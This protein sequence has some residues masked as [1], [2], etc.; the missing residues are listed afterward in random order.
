MDAEH[1]FEFELDNGLFDIVDSRGLRPWEAVR[2]YV[3]NRIYTSFDTKG[4]KVPPVKVAPRRI[5]LTKLFRYSRRKIHSI[6]YLLLHRKS[7]IFFLLCSRDKYNGFYYDKICGSLFEESDRTKV[8]AIESCVHD[9]NYKYAG[10]TCEQSFFSLVPKFFSVDF[11]FSL[12]KDRILVQYPDA[13]IEITDLEKWYKEFLAQYYYFRFL[14]RFCGTR[15][16]F[17]VQ[18]GILKGVFA[19]AK[20]YGVEV[21]E[22]QHGQIS[23]NHPA[24]SYPENVDPSKIYQPSKL[25]VFGEFWTKNRYYP[26]VENVVVGNEFYHKKSSPLTV[27]FD[28]RFLVVSNNLEGKILARFVKT[29]LDID[30]GFSFFFKLHPN[31]YNEYTYYEDEFRQYKGVEVVSDSMSINDML[32]QSEGVLVVQSTVELEALR[33]GK[34]VFVIEEG[35]YKMMD[36]VFDEPGVHLVNSAQDFVT[37][38]TSTNAEKLKPRLDIFMK[39]NPSVINSL[40]LE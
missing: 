29:I 25:L 39:Y 9:F 22:F 37:K 11:D 17:M 32:S 6:I 1:F 8:F 35:T 31:Q 30:S 13:P 16:M 12:I 27:Q 20:E 21:F 38:Y 28:K 36:F 5:T 24:Y 19:A 10:F 2:Y 26:G 15:K 23:I 4:G 14:F 34:K 40:L 18:N 33:D 3:Y 7:P